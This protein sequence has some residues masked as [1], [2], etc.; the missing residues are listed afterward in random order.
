MFK[1]LIIISIGIIAG[2]IDVIPMV[3]QK[4]D[5]YANISAFVHWIVVTI[6]IA[7]IQIP[8]APWLKG[9]LVAEM[10]AIP[11]MIQ[12]LKDSPKSIVPI[13]IFSAVLGTLVGIVT[14]LV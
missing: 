1:L 8:I 10:A 4:L 12:Q 9:F 11:V 14:A 13:A 2:I 6:F 3:I 5:K 7:Y